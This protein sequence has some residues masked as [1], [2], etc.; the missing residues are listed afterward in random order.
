MIASLNCKGTD[1]CDLPSSSFNS[2]V[3]AA[4]PVAVFEK[5][6]FGTLLS[7]LPF[8]ENLIE[9][10]SHILKF[11]NPADHEN[12][13][14]GSELEKSDLPATALIMPPQSMTHKDK[15]QHLEI[16]KKFLDGAESF[17]FSNLIQRNIDESQVSGKIGDGEYQKEQLL[18]SILFGLIADSISCPPFHSCIVAML[19]R[20]FQPYLYDRKKSKDSDDAKFNY[21]S[22]YDSISLLSVSLKP[23]ILK[24]S[25]DHDIFITRLCDFV[26]LV[27]TKVSRVV[28]A[29]YHHS[30][31]LK[32]ESQPNI[33]LI[34]L[35]RLDTVFNSSERFHFDLIHAAL[36]ALDLLI[37]PT[38]LTDSSISNLLPRDILTIL[39]SIHIHLAELIME[40]TRPVVQKQLA[41][42]IMARIL[43]V[44]E[45]LLEK[46]VIL[47]CLPAGAPL[48]SWL[49]C[50]KN[51]SIPIDVTSTPA[52]I[53]YTARGILL[54]LSPSLLFLSDSISGTNI[55][56][57]HLFPYFMSACER[58]DADNIY[59]LLAYQC[60]SS[61]LS[62]VKKAIEK[63]HDV[64]ASSRKLL[65]FFSQHRE[66]LIEFVFSN[67]NDSVDSI[68]HHALTIFEYI[69]ELDVLTIS[70]ENP[71]EPT[72]FLVSTLT[73]VFKLDDSI[74]GKYG[75]IK[76]IMAKF[77]IKAF[78]RIHGTSFVAEMIKSM[79]HRHA[80]DCIVQAATA[81]KAEN[82][83]DEHNWR[84]TWALPLKHS[85]LSANASRRLIIAEL[86]LPRLF[87][88]V[89]FL[90]DLILDIPRNDNEDPAICITFLC[91]G[92]RCG[93]V[94]SIMRS[95]FSDKITTCMMHPDQLARTSAL[96][97]V[98][99]SKRTTEPV[100]DADY[101]MV[102]TFLSSNLDSSSPKFR[103]DSVDH[104]RKLL[105]RISSN[106][107]REFKN[108]KNNKRIS[109]QIQI[110]NNEDNISDYTLDDSIF[111]ALKF[112]RWF[113]DLLFAGIRPMSGFQRRETCLLHL[114][115]LIEVLGK[116]I[117]NCND[118]FF[119]STLP[120]DRIDLLL[121][122]LLDPFDSNQKL[123]LSILEL[124]DVNP[125]TSP[126]LLLQWALYLAENAKV[127]HC[128]AAANL[129]Q[130][131]TKCL[132]A[133]EYLK[134]G[135]HKEFF[136]HDN[137][138]C[139]VVSIV[140][141][142]IKEISLLYKK[143]LAHVAHVPIHGF[144]H[145]FRILLET[146]EKSECEQFTQKAK[147]VISDIVQIIFPV[148]SDPCCGGN[149]P[150]HIMNKYSG[151]N[152]TFQDDDN[153]QTLLVNSW[154]AIK[155]I[156]LLY[157]YV[158][159][160]EPHCTAIGKNLLQMLLKVQHYGAMSMLSEGL[161]QLCKK[162]K[163]TK[164]HTLPEKWLQVLIQDIVA[165]DGGSIDVTVTRRSAGLPHA[166][167]SLI[168]SMPKQKIF[169]F[170]GSTM[171]ELMQFAERKY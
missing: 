80:A 127:A 133:Q 57:T 159:S 13:N 6:D 124:V 105:V 44:Q 96:A 157:G 92:V 146:M 10:L 138:I 153:S 164:S 78:I 122:T 87:D 76:I 136:A 73:K 17:L 58:R 61:W 79:M 135:T 29:P 38:I 132:K 70:P 141:Q 18:I 60:L 51:E 83:S 117:E 163:T 130:Y 125:S 102:K 89:P 62:T 82:H 27:A 46:G 74:K 99:N 167:I 104:I 165:S 39:A 1:S 121:Y 118:I 107:R 23:T 5:K 123:A 120:Q 75:A 97:I 145:C 53:L 20:C 65:C 160:H 140:F 34:L 33:L 54:G 128:N 67:W 168:S 106:V 155:E 143:D 129:M 63:N 47:H 103:K 95:Q 116:P 42:V 147:N 85:M 4:S 150:S 100:L 72:P 142:K 37:D 24:L 11:T 93:I 25:N 50:L 81:F 137:P 134:G 45:C 36:E 154:R 14:S 31:G 15:R 101:E 35:S 32:S 110:L 152:D 98:C 86:L 52:G 109:L 77:G 131:V 59:H 148:V 2:T 90:L 126:S 43:S 49:S 111:L 69:V 41:G 19:V 91:A 48:Y 88:V 12:Y 55:M 22:T 7:S 71:L 115:S 170:F 56:E 112:L 9:K 66:L 171:N 108:S 114:H 16:L 21:Q 119:A 151:D 161:Y 166:I 28:F 3:S 94:T 144:I 113:A 68:R 40:N 158:Y 156:A 26:C 162:L 139:Y 84:V 169:V 64:F 8:P 30:R 149:V